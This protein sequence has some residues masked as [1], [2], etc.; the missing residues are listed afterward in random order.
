MSDLQ[1]NEPSA[2]ASERKEAYLARVSH[3]QM[4]LMPR[5]FEEGLRMAELYSRSTIVPT[6]YRGNPGNAFIAIEMGMSVGLFPAQALQSIT[7]INGR[8]CIW[9]DGMLGVVV[10]SPVFES[11]E[12][13]LKDGIATCTVKR[14]N[15]TNLVSRSFSVDDAKKAG[16]W[17]KP[18]SWQSNPNRMLQMRARAFALR[19]VFADVLRGIASAEEMLDVNAPTVETKPD[20][21][22]L[23]RNDLNCSPEQWDRILTLWDTLDVSQPKRILMAKQYAGRPEQLLEALA[24]QLPVPVPSAIAAPEIAPPPVVVTRPAKRRLAK[25]RAEGMATPSPA[26]IPQV[27]PEPETA[28]VMTCPHNIDLREPCDQCIAEADAAK[29][30]GKPFL[31]SKDAIPF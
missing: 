28:A 24:L 15:W 21:A 12:E 25:A 2:E 3:V 29:A 22:V 6:E 8:P 5:N 20:P 11:I 23:L 16:L 19:D 10:A 18:G 27:D 17:N 1:R 31:A 13:Q 26:P 7:V 30:A 4:G 14:K 9:G